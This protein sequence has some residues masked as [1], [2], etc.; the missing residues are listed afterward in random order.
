MN[1]LEK[2]KKQELIP[3]KEAEYQNLIRKGFTIIRTVSYPFRIEIKLRDTRGWQ[4]LEKG[5]T[6]SQMNQRVYELLQ[7]DK[8]IKMD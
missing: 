7:N 3:I 4:L 2:V 8:T 5:I 6:E 1:Y